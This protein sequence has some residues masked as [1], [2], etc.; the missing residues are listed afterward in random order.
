MQSDRPGIL[1]LCTGNSCRSQM[2]AAYLEE[3]AGDR[4]QVYSAG[5]EPEEDIHPLTRV[6]LSEDGLDISDRRPTHFREYLGRIPVYYLL[7]VCDG[8]AKSCPSVWPG[9]MERLSW[10]FDDPAAVDGT[11]DEKLAAFRQTR[12]EIKARVKS[13]TDSLTLQPAVNEAE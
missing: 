8:A 5:T 3:L 11:H 1:I 13:W 7:I 6:V 4:L 12:D 10:P 9:V 2:A